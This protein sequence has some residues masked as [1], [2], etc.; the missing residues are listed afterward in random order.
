M[1]ITPP[2]TRVDDTIKWF[3]KKKMIEIDEYTEE[4]F[5]SFIS[6]EHYNY[7]HINK[8]GTIDA[9]GC[10]HVV[11]NTYRFAYTW[12]NKTISGKKAYVRGIKALTD[13]FGSIAIQEQDLIYNKFKRIV[14]V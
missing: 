8:E 1:G 6:R 11:D 7:I 10:I 9:F 3:I 5:N 12:C 13:L 14:G 4:E 2:I